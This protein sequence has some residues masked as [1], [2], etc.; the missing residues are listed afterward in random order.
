MK[1]KNNFRRALIYLLTTVIVCLF[2]MGFVK[3]SSFYESSDRNFFSFISMVRY[4]LIDYPIETVSNVVKDTSM[5]WDVRH[6]NDK[7]RT[8]LETSHHWQTRLNELESEVAELKALNELNSVYSEYT[9]VNAT[10]KNRSSEKWDSV[11][12]IDKGSQDGVA[13]G[14]G[15]VAPKGIIGKVLSVDK[16]QSLVALLIANDENSNATVQ[17][18]VSKG[19]YVQGI[20]NSYDHEKKLFSVVL[21]ESTSTIA[22]EMPVSTASISSVYP[23]GLFVG[24]VDSVKNVADSVGV[25]VYVKPSVDYNNIKYVSVVKKS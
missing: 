12:T 18:E 3:K 20:L 4:G 19:N 8:Q 2:G 10:V 6:E 22:A 16:N 9:Q 25:L 15:V 24:K 23:S 7:L 5:M 13:V 1:R 17:I 21:L 11:I 14:D